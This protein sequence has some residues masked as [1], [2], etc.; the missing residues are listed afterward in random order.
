MNAITV[1]VSMSDVKDVPL[2]R[3]VSHQPSLGFTNSVLILTMARG[4]T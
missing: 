2:F 4:L 3:A 1:P